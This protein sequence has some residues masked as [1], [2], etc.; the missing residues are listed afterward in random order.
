MRLAVLT[1]CRRCVAVKKDPR[2]DRDGR[3]MDARHRPPGLR[4][5]VSEH[6]GRGHRTEPEHDGELDLLPD[7]RGAGGLRRPAGR[8][9]T[10]PSDRPRSATRTR[11]SA[12]ATSSTL[13]PPASPS[14]TGSPPPATHAA[15]Q[16]GRRR[17]PRLGDRA[18]EHARSRWSPA[19][20][21][22]PPHRENLL[23]ATLP[24]DR[25]RGGG[26]HPREQPAMSSGVTVSSEYGY[27]SFAKAKKKRAQGA[28]PARRGRTRQPLIGSGPGY[29]EGDRL[30]ES[31][32]HDLADRVEAQE[33]RLT[34]SH[35][36]A[37]AVT[38]T[39]PPSARETTR[40]ARLTSPPK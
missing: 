4:V 32:E 5:L 12:R 16:L 23:D 11:W 7:Q 21:N 10:P 40:C 30:G 25:D 39:S 9:R 28:R 27:R 34:R 31:L 6:G 14:S 2:R 18:A 19:W 17:E 37:P 36:P 1:R 29:I 22:S 13:P 20:M 15:A 26:R 8:S 38:S 3:R 35:R 33:V 24:R